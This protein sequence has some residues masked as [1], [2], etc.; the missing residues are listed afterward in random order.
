MDA[1]PLLRN[2]LSFEILSPSPFGRGSG[3][4]RRCEARN[5][6]GS[7]SSQSLSPALSR[8][9]RAFFHLLKKS[10]HLVICALTFLQ[11]IAGLAQ[12][13]I[14]TPQTATVTVTFTP[15]HPANRFIP[16]RALGAGVDGHPIG[17]TVRQLSP[18]NIKAMLSAGLKPRTYRLRTELAGEAWHWNPNGTWSDPA[19]RQGNWT[20][21]SEPGRPIHVCYGYRLPRRGNTIDQANDEAY[22]RHDDGA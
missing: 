19:R 7:V 6:P 5:P 2:P 22:S 21:S 3:R 16:A 13:Q 15:G 11:P 9:K 4:G 8:K 20:S 12:Q 1:S 17:E 18:A 10:G 14:P